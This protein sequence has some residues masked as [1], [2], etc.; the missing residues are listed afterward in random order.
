MAMV[1]HWGKRDATTKHKANSQKKKKKKTAAS[2]EMM[3][4][5]IT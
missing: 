2:M 1:A 5:Q 3:Q 4:S